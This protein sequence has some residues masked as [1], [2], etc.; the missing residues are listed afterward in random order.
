[1]VCRLLTLEQGNANDTGVASPPSSVH[2]C[3]SDLIKVSD[4][5]QTSLLP[6]QI[7]GV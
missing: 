7:E 3:H 2:F 6:A 4:E 1:M 5:R